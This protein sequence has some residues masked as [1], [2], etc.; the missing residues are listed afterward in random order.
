MDFTMRH[1]VLIGSQLKGISHRSN[2]LAN[3]MNGP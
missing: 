1:L 2:S 3:L